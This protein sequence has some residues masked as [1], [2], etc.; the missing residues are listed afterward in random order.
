MALI[1]ACSFGAPAAV[2]GCLSALAGATAPPVGAL[3]ASRWRHQSRGD[4]EK[5]SVT[6]SLEATLNDTTFLIGPVLVTTLSATISSS[7]GLMIAV[8]LVGTGMLALVAQKSSEPPPQDAGR[9]RILD[10]RLLNPK[11]LS[12]FLVNMGMGLFFGGVPVTVTAFAIA[13]NA[14]AAA[15]PIAAVS[16]V[17][18]ILAGLVFGASGA[19]ARPLK[20]MILVSAAMAVGCAALSMVPDLGL[21]FVGYGVVGGGV[22]LVLIPASILLQRSTPSTVYT[23]AMT[24]INSASAGG[25][26]ISAPLA[27][28][29]IQAN[30]WPAG[31]L[32]TSALT[33]LVPVV[34]AMSYRSLRAANEAD[35]RPGA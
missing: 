23:Q 16:S 11:F 1:V 30:G 25:I 3:L 22:A 8:A 7:A 5:M 17:V 13:H 14:G 27:G 9:S 10:S 28:Y 33:A 12:L 31:F 4:T 32:L 24:W 15:G 34:A 26:A 19:S 21:M 2:L 29:A 18:S 20:V 35:P 6:L